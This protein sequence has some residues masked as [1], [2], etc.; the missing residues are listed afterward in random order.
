ME[1]RIDGGVATIITDRC[2]PPAGLGPSPSTLK[3]VLWCLRGLGM[4]GSDICVPASIIERRTCLSRRAVT[5]AMA[6]LREHGIITQTRAPSPGQATRYVM[7]YERLSEWV[8][9]GDL[10]AVRIRNGRTRGSRSVAPEATDREHQRPPLKSTG[11]P[12]PTSCAPESK[13]VASQSTVLKEE[14]AYQQIPA[15]AAARLDAE[16]LLG[17]AAA[18][19]LVDG[20]EE[21]IKIAKGAGLEIGDARQCAQ[22]LHS[23]GLQDREIG[24]NALERLSERMKGGGIKNPVGLLRSF[25]E[26][27]DELESSKRELLRQRKRDAKRKDFAEFVREKC[28]QANYEQIQVR[29]EAILQGVLGIETTGELMPDGCFRQPLNGWPTMLDFVLKHWDE[30]RTRKAVANA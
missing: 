12:E 1:N 19:D 21:W 8:E 16:Q 10:D 17:A 25:V 18:A 7:D 20:V 27:H 23:L 4:P 14:T 3:S 9:E 22:A 11:A 29:T 24:I 2:I 5:R 28:S 30:I 13:S 6:C 26:Q 15:A